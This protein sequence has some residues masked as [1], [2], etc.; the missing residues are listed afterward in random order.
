[1]AF[2]ASDLT[3]FSLVGRQCQTFEAN[4]QFLFNSYTVIL[5]LQ[6]ESLRSRDCGLLPQSSTINENNFEVSQRERPPKCRP[7][8]SASDSPSTAACWATATTMPVLHLPVAFDPVLTAEPGRLVSLLNSKTNILAEE[9][10]F[11][12]KYK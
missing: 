10:H 5:S 6:A 4:F 12:L 1:M 8:G 3:F 11:N 9:Q 2:V 7:G